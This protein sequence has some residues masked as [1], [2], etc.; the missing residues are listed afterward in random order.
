MWIKRVISEKL[1][2]LL[3]QR[4]AIVLTGAR[5]TGKTSLL[6]HL[7]PRHRFVS[8][9]LPALA[10]EAERNPEAFIRTHGEPLIIDEIQYAPGLFRYLKILIDQDRGRSGRF[11]LTGSQ[12]FTLMKG[13]SDSLAGRV[14]ILDLETLSLREILDSESVSE[15]MK[16]PESVLSRGGFPELYEKPNLD[17]QD[18]HR[19]YLATYLE[20]DVRALVNVGKLRDFERFIRATALRSGQ[21]LNQSELA[22]DVGISPSTAGEWL[23][24]LEASNQI[25]LLEPWF[26][27]QQKRMTKSPKLYLKDAGML[28][29]LLGV[30]TPEDLLRSPLR[31]AIWETFVCAELRKKRVGQGVAPDFF[32]YRDRSREVDFLVHRGGRFELLEAKWAENPS[33]SDFEALLIVGSQLGETNIIS[34]KLVCRTPAAS[35]VHEKVRAVPIGDL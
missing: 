3:A 34:R 9:D 16:S 27:N 8:L 24:V 13:V 25:M 32:F 1:E 18:F 23:S 4:P 7:F 33:A 19:S 28:L 31:G 2:E 26:S 30:T 11:I 14:S 35:L 6:K 12:K 22:R 29:Y 20:R 15:P 5:Q 21:L 10:D 17:A